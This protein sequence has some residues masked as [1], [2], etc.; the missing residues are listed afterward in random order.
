[1]TS[2]TN[3]GSDA[4]IRRFTTGLASCLFQYEDQTPD[5][6]FALAE[7]KSEHL[8]E[9]RRTLGCLLDILADWETTVGPG[10]NKNPR[11]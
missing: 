4:T 2:P 1:M 9:L 3:L 7:R 8:A 6:A 10:Q 5:D 11:G